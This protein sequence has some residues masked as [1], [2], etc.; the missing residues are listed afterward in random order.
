[1]SHRTVEAHKTRLM[2]KY[3]VRTTNELI[4]HL[5]GWRSD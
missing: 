1:M 5:I 4:A 3:G 2:C